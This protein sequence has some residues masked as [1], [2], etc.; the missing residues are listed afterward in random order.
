VVLAQKCTTDN[1]G[2]RENDIG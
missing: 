2:F 1:R